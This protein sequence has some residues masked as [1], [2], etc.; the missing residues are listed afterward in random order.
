[1]CVPKRGLG[2]HTVVAKLSVPFPAADA[3]CALRSLAPYFGPKD[4]GEITEQ[5]LLHYIRGTQPHGRRRKLRAIVR[6]DVVWQTA[7]YEQ[8]EQ[9]LQDMLR[10]KT[11]RN[12]NR[13]ALPRELVHDYEHSNRPAIVRAVEHEVVRP[14][15]IRSLGASSH[16]RTVGEP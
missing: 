1:M 4:L 16:A 6:P 10:A 3:A 11:S 8:I 2:N 12:V 15:V 7:L 14:D 9:P 5:D 13:Q